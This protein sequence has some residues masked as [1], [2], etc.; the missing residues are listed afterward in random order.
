MGE[1]IHNKGS[2]TS[3]GH[4]GILLVNKETSPEPLIGI[5]YSMNEIVKKY[6]SRVIS[7]KES[8]TSLTY[9]VSISL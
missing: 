1:D 6:E 4:F 2:E 8:S 5:P 7:Y 9:S 3:R